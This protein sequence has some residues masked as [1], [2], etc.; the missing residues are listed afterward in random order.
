SDLFFGQIYGTHHCGPPTGEKK[1]ERATT[2]LRVVDGIF[3]Q[4]MFV[5]NPVDF[6]D[7]VIKHAT[8]Q[9][10]A[11]PHDAGA[12]SNQAAQHTKAESSPRGTPSVGEAAT[13]CSQASPDHGGFPGIA[14]GVAEKGSEAVAVQKFFLPF[15][16]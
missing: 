2:A 5:A 3:F 6:F 11:A 10:A 7:G 15:P 1:A 16:R 12:K 14:E 8:A 13:Q 4:P 9:A